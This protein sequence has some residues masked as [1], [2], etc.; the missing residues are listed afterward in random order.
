MSKENDTY[1]HGHLSAAL[2]EAAIEMIADSGVDKM[3]MRALSK[4]VGVSRA[5]PYR[6]FANKSALLAAVAEEGF[7]SMLQWLQPEGDNTDRDA[8]ASF[9]AMGVAY[10]SFALSNPTHYRLMFGREFVDRSAYPMLQEAAEALFA[11][12]LGMIERCQ[13]A[14]QMRLE[15]PHLLAQVVWA[16]VH[17]LSLLL[18]DSQLNPETDPD[19]IASLATRLLVEGLAL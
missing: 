16:N 19:I 15:E 17:G 12:L 5:A 6:H 11:L 18:L 1:H 14:G 9:Q 4:R 7:R 8:L 13:Q 3:T 2:L 10:V